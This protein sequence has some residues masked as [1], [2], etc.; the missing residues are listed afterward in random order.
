MSLLTAISDL[1]VVR[2]PE[3]R[4]KDARKTSGRC[5]LLFEGSERAVRAQIETARALVGGDEDASVWDEVAARQLASR[6]RVGFDRLDTFLAETPEAV[7]RVSAL[8]A[9]VP[10]PVAYAPSPLVERVRAEL[11]AT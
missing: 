6:G 5:C 11:T 1:G 9:Y 10:Q 3:G 2:V 7:V 8:N 4:P